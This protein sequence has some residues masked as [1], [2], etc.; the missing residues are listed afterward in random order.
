MRHNFS[1]H[2][3]FHKNPVSF[4]KNSERELLQYCLG[5]T[6]YMPSTRQIADKIIKNSIPELTSMVMC[7]EDA[8]SL[9]DL[10]FG[11]AN[12]IEEL[13]NLDRA[14]KNKELS[15]DNLPLI[16]LRVRDIK[17][18]LSFT[19]KLSNEHAQILTGFVFPK[20]YSDN[21]AEYLEQLDGLNKKL[22]TKLY[23]MPILEGESIANVE[24]RVSEL[25]KLKSIIDPF[26]NIILNIRI[27]GTDFSS[28]FG[29][30]RG[31]NTSIYDILPVRDIISDIL[32]FFG[33]TSDEYTISAPVWEYFLAYNDDNIEKY[34]GKSM[35]LSL[36]TNEVIVNQA[37]DGLLREVTR[38]I[39]NGMI[40]KTVIHPSHL[41][42]VN[43]MQ[44]ITKE[45]YEDALQIINAEGG[46]MKSKGGNKMNEVG[47]HKSWA[48][49]ICL[50]A[51]IYG[52]IENENDY[53]TLFKK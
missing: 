27:G 20:F 9:N 19:S 2:I 42:F 51:K 16:F 23:G 21:A 11:E 13:D 46:V 33:R 6:L 10:P 17:Q 50:R 43:S 35:N 53:L 1:K 32:N 44:A 18:F 29:V 3:V 41:K 34:I 37:I 7:F 31:I 48:T 26:K 39:A 40:G 52:V 24:T 22:G 38:D 30:R 45:E 47:P 4:D 8:I 49:K 36:M 28:L 12:V 25:I 14:V 15:I 5:A